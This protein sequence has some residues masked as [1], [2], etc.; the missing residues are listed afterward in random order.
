[1][2]L[3]R[4]VAVAEAGL[5]T[6]AMNRAAAASPSLQASGAAPNI[7]I[8]R[9]PAN[10]YNATLVGNATATGGGASPNQTHHWLVEATGELGV[11]DARVG[12]DLYG[13]QYR[14]EPIAAVV[15]GAALSISPAVP[16]ATTS[17]TSSAMVYMMR[18][19]RVAVGANVSLTAAALWW[20]GTAAGMPSPADGAVDRVTAWSRTAANASA[21]AAVF[22]LTISG[23]RFLSQ[24]TEALEPNPPVL[25]GATPVVATLAPALRMA[26]VLDVTTLPGIANA[27]AE[28]D[29]AQSWRWFTTA[30]GHAQADRMLFLAGRMQTSTRGNV[31]MDYVTSWDTVAGFL[32]DALADPLAVVSGDTVAVNGRV[33][34]LLA[35]S[36][37]GWV[38]ARRTVT[39]QVAVWGSLVTLVA[40]VVIALSIAGVV[41]PWEVALERSKAAAAQSAGAEAMQDTML[42]FLSHELRK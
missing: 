25:Y 27:S 1:V 8:F 28:L 18:P 6:T 41:A 26:A 30:R 39:W 42:G 34:L 29:G 3:I 19:L 14:H 32:T 15:G 11:R 9:G 31:R 22:A 35:T 17:A 5:W 13:E 7:T 38:A 40:A 37:A 33:Y 36:S 12:L 16:P 2:W 10:V 4:P 20:N 24:F 23:R 21:T